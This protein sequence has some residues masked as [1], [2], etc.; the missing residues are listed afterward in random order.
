MFE[1]T[2]GFMHKKEQEE[3]TLFDDL[4]PCHEIK[5]RGD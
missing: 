1:N 3:D 4:S 5:A 2:I